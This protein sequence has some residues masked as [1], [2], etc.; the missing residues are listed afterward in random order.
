MPSLPRISPKPLSSGSP[1]YLLPEDLINK[2]AAGEV[3]ERPASVI[4]ELIENSLDAGATEIEVQVEVYGKRLIRVA[5]N[6]CGMGREDAER[7]LLRHATSKIRE[8]AD[9]FSIST[10]GFRGEALASIAAVSRLTITTRK[11]GD[12]TGYKVADSISAAVPAAA[13]EGTVV[14]VRELFHNTPARRKFLKTDA[15]ELR[16]VIEAVVHY[17]LINPDVA[18]RLS[19]GG[20][21]LLDSPGSGNWRETIGSIYGPQLA[22][23]LLEIPPEKLQEP[24]HGELADSPSGIQVQG[25][26][27]PPHH[28]RNDKNQQAF[29]VNGRWVRSTEIAGALHDAYHSMLFLERHPVAVLQL[30]VEPETVDV[31]V[32]PTKKEIK[33]ENREAVYNAVYA[34]V[35]RTLERNNLVPAMLAERQA[36]LNGGSQIS[37][38]VRPEARPIPKEVRQIPAASAQRYAFETSRQ[39]VFQMP[40]T[41]IAET[42][43]PENPEEQQDYYAPGDYMGD[44]IIGEERGVAKSAITLET[45]GKIAASGTLPSIKLLGQINKTYFAAE[46]AKGLLLLDQHAVHERVL[47]EKFMGQYLNRKVEVQHLLQPEVLELTPV[48][49]AAVCQHLGTLRQLGFTLEEFGSNAFRLN[50]LPE[51][52]GRLQGKE[53]LFDIL[54]S[55]EERQGKMEEAQEEVITR[56]ACRAAVMAGEELTLSQMEKYLGELHGTRLPFTCPHGRPTMFTVSIEELEKKFRRRG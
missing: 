24:S 38:V 7:S 47:Y 13:Q 29:F 28:A 40:E 22:K 15:V 9:L 1:I 5:D 19:H 37:E 51:F 53:L 52:L 33:F 6:G 2:I 14:E 55:L 43:I 11:K 42:R 34:A 23:E 17:A 54:A 30:I 27:A 20:Q 48:E 25:Y 21:V 50:T 10:L 46:T 44:D 36:S 4:K 45:P 26:I 32:H 39:A 12:D 31:N 18:F 3:I 49:Y 16:H 56:M 8:V 41:Q 35:R